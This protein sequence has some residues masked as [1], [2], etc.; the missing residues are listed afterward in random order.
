MMYDIP[1]SDC[2]EW[3]SVKERRT[4]E[5]LR[6]VGDGEAAGLHGSMGGKTRMPGG[7]EGVGDDP[8]H[9]ARTRPRIYK[10][11][12]RRSHQHAASRQLRSLVS[13]AH[14]R[15]ECLGNPLNVLAHR[16]SKTVTL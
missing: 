4:P 16:Q 13:C 15:L 9:R 1:G 7:M 3:S 14:Q 5:G 10:T 6:G 11:H 12:D 8:D 2:H